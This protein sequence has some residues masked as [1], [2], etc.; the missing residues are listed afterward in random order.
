MSPRPAV[1]PGGRSARVRQSVHTA[2]RELLQE[3]GRDSLTVPLVAARAGVTPSTVYRRWGTLRELLSDVAVERLR[4]GSPPEDLGSLRADLEDWATS[5]AQQT[6]SPA[7]QA[8]LRDTLAGDPD[9]SNSGRCAAYAAGQI[10]TILSRAAARGEHAPDAEAVLDHVVAPLVYRALF[11]QEPPDA[12]G[13]ARS[14]VATVL[15][16]LI[17][18]P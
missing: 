7:G 3:R 13:Y 11:R 8:R 18:L 9:G 5:F 2:V 16:R 4:P 15:Y 14:L 17:P 10:E 1:R 12:D 6:A